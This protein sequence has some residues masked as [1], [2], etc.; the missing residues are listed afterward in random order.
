VV[1]AREERTAL[2]GRALL[3]CAGARD[4]VFF[5]FFFFF[6]TQGENS[7]AP[8]PKLDPNSLAASTAISTN[9]SSSTRASRSFFCPYQKMGNSQATKK[10]TSPVQLMQALR[11][12]VLTPGRG[13]APEGPLR[14]STEL[15]PSPYASSWLFDYAFLLSWAKGGFYLFI[16]SA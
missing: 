14:E 15:Y 10:G 2:L 9:T 7:C 6:S 3:G 12:N 16:Y 13:G 4:F 5:F 11:K 1:L 8:G